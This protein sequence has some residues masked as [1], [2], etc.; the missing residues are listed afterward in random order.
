MAAKSVLTVLALGVAVTAVAGAGDASAY[1]RRVCAL[2]GVDDGSSQWSRGECSVKNDDASSNHFIWY[3]LPIDTAPGT[4]RARAHVQGGGLAGTAV[5][6]RLRVF[7]NDSTYQVGSLNCTSGAGTQ[8]LTFDNSGS[9][10]FVP[11]GGSATLKLDVDPLLRVY[12][13]EFTN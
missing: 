12:D 11:A 9:V 3:S 7:Q 2:A 13:V 10:M 1:T 6:G 4:V 8:Q 5:C